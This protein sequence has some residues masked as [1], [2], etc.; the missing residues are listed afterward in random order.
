MYKTISIHIDTYQKLNAVAARLKKTKAQVIED[1]IGELIED[2][3]EKDKEQLSKFNI[4]MKERIKQIKL[5]EGVKVN[6]DDT[7]K[8][9]SEL[10]EKEI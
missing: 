3:K 10:D 8:W 1:A 2:M 5:P 4:R 6:T 7:D 9:F